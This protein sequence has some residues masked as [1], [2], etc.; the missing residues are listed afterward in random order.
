MRGVKSI[1]GSGG[2]SGR[3]LTRGAVAAVLCAALSGCLPAPCGSE[4]RD[5]ARETLT[6]LRAAAPAP[7]GTDRGLVR[8]TDWAALPVLGDQRYE[9]FSSY[10]R[11][12]GHEPFEPGGKDFNNFITSAVEQLTVLLERLEHAVFEPQVQGYLLAAVDDGPGYVS[13]LFFTRFSGLESLTDPDFLSD[14]AVGAY[15]NE[16]LRVYVDDLS[17][18]ALVIPVADLG[19]AAPLLAPL[20]GRYSAATLS[21]VPIAFQQRLW[22]TLD[23]LCP[24]GGYYY[25]VDVQCSTD[26]TVSLSPRLDETPAFAAAAALIAQAGEN[27]NDGYTLAV[28][29]SPFE[30]PPQ[31]TTTVLARDTGGTVELIAFSLAEGDAAALRSVR[32]R[33]LYDDADEPAIDVPLDAFFGLREG[34]APFATLPMRVQVADGR[35]ALAC[36][37][38]APFASRVRVALRNLGT[39]SVRLNATIGVDNA[40]PPEPWGY[41]HA[42]Y[43]AVAG[44]QPADSQFA[45]LRV[46]GRGRYVGTML[47]A[48]GWSDTRPGQPQAPLSILEGNET[49]IID[50]Q[51]RIRGTGTEDYYNGAFYFA[52]G[53]VTQA[54]AAANVVYDGPEEPGFVSCCRWHVLTDAID[55]QRSFVLRFQYGDDNPALVARYATVAFYYLDRAVPGD[56]DAGNVQVP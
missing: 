20:A 35:I 4:G 9:Q 52:T 41:L 17:A 32:L 44:A 27:P 38:P 10:N 46:R 8:L 54:F 40:L 22:V 14:P 43:A 26:T 18:P 29:D 33:V 15:A 25:H 55:F 6:E 28:A 48:A 45:A 24:L 7:A 34:V 36:Y 49:G 39:Q 37:L 47:A 19:T 51:T 23:N 56:A 53:P 16:V 2:R 3:V 21:Y 5:A 50:G 1:Y 11:T 13:R 12:P 30:L 31:T 42:R